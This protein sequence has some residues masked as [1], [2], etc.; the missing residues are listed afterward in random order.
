MVA[1]IGVMVEARHSRDL[2]QSSHTLPVGGFW[3]DGVARTS[4]GLDM[5]K[6]GKEPKN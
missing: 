1:A 2:L 6:T 4:V 3:E 5:G